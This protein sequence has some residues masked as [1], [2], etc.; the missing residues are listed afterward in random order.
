MFYTSRLNGQLATQTQYAPHRG[1]I[2][3][4]FTPTSSLPVPVY[5]SGSLS[6]SIIL[7]PVSISFVHVTPSCWLLLTFVLSSEITLHIYPYSHHRV[8]ISGPCVTITLPRSDSDGGGGDSPEE[9]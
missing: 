5:P 6:I 3:L 9:S 2:S 4:S 1:I 8:P 7:Y